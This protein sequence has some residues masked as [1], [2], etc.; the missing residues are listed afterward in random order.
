M[1]RSSRGQG[2]SEAVGFILILAVVIVVV[3]LYLVYL[4]PAMGREDEIAQMASVKERFTEFKLNIDAL[5]TSRRCTSEYGPALSLGSGEATGIL[6]YFP[7]FS[8]PR[9]GAVLALNQRAES[10]TIISDSYLLVDSGG[11]NESRL[12]NNTP[13]TLPVNNT[14]AHFYIAVSTTDLR[15]ERGVLVDAPSVDVW[16][17]ITPVYHSVDLV[18]LTLNESHYVTSF[19]N[20]T[21]YRLTGT[22]VTVTTNFG[23]KQ[24]ITSLPVYR[25]ISPSTFYTV[26]LVN[27]VY[28]LSSLFLSPQSLSLQASHASGI[29]AL[30]DVRYGFVPNVTNFSTPRALGAIEY[31]SNNLFYTPQTYYYQLGGVFLEQPDGSTSE[32]PPDVSILM[33]NGSPRVSVGEILIWGGIATV[34]VSGSGPITLTSAVTD[35]NSAPLPPGNNTRWVNLSILAASADAARMWNKTFADLASQ[36]GLSSSAYKTGTAGNVAFL[37]VTGDPQLYDIQLS[38]TEVNVSADFVNEYSPGG[39]SRAWRGVPGYVP[40][41]P[42]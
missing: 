26:D 33:V 19:S 2:I 31:R 7:F 34:N 9:A 40:P 22:D 10:I 35:I 3:S 38:L 8:P 39:I 11:Y 32:V 12:I 17:N 30:Y 24:V 16:V 29:T 41:T 1:M 6:S 25:N 27:P 18:N 5:W 14:P 20:Y 13:L 36:G 42:P 4:M 37:N 15:T 21:D 23:G 28:G